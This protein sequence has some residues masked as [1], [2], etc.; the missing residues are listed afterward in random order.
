MTIEN[1]KLV[2]NLVSLGKTSRVKFVYDY[3][4]STISVSGVMDVRIDKEFAEAWILEANSA[5]EKLSKKIDIQLKAQ[6]RKEISK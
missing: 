3:G 2:S 1:E 6:I 4:R 5:L